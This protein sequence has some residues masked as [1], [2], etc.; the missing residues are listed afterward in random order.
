MTWPSCDPGGNPRCLITCVGS[1]TWN[2]IHNTLEVDRKKACVCT[3]SCFIYCCF[4]RDIV[5]ASMFC[6]KQLSKV[7][8]KRKSLFTGSRIVSTGCRRGSCQCG[9]SN[10]WQPWFDVIYSVSQS[11][12]RERFYRSRF[13]CFSFDL[14]LLSRLLLRKCF[15]SVYTGRGY[16]SC[17]SSVM[18]RRVLT[19]LLSFSVSW[20]TI[21][22]PLMLFYDHHRGRLTSVLIP[23]GSVI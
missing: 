13:A 10:S 22:L 16:L 7:R 15:L 3:L 5:A 21:V 2:L 19:L 1:V 8:R 17:E 12:I 20:R 9:G 6:Q 14:L 11:F 23:K 4:N 18:Q